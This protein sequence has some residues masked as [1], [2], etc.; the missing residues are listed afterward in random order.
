M[1]QSR[2]EL[3]LLLCAKRQRNFGE[4]SSLSVKVGGFG[5]FKMVKVGL[6]WDEFKMVKVLD[7][8][9]NQPPPYFI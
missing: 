5:E 4:I 8:L 1:S 3:Q 6:S 2:R 7:P 9:D